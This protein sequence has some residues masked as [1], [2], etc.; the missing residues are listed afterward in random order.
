[1]AAKLASNGEAAY[2]C[3]PRQMMVRKP[4]NLNDHDLIEGLPILETPISQP[5]TMSYGIQRIRLAETSRNITDRY[6]MSWGRG[7]DSLT[8]EDALG[9]D[10]D[11]QIMINDIPAFFSMSQQ[12]LLSTYGMAIRTA[13]D[14]F[15]QGRV[16][17]VLIYA[18]RC[19]IQAPFFVRSYASKPFAQSR[20]ICLRSAQ[21][22]IEAQYQIMTCERERPCST[23]SSALLYGTFLSS[24][25]LL[26]DLCSN[27]SDMES[28]QNIRR[29]MDITKAFQ[30][31]DT[32]RH[33]SEVS[34]RFVKSAVQVL[35]K[36][37]ISPWSLGSAGE[38]EVNAALPRSQPNTATVDGVNGSAG[39]M[40]RMVYDDT[41]NVLDEGLSRADCMDTSTYLSDL[42]MSLEQGYDL[43]DFNCD[44]ILTE[45]PIAMM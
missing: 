16:L 24:I 1:M 8:Q 4:L 45:L 29:R 15:Y 3:H 14:I 18:L 2:N 25:M 10:T 32:A 21:L 6:W 23:G 40:P 44:N 19:K 30:I 37:Q 7:A 26:M 20:D 22:I 39:Y 17:F 38:Q 33:D 28:A 43:T 27:V 13:Q 41:S 42:A 9:M 31:L 35:K 12:E 11:I 36:R 5:T 34:G